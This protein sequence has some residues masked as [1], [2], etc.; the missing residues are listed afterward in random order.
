[1]G[2]T[3]SLSSTAAPP[4]GRSIAS[5][6]WTLTSGADIATLSGETTPNAAT[7]VASAAG[8]ITAQLTVTDTQG[9]QASASVTVTVVNPATTAA[10]GGGS[11][12][13][14]ALGWPWLAGLA[15]ALRALPRRQRA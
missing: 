3:I 2:G 4:S 8:S 13:G 11:S 15:L 5:Y 10:A 7:I 14:G 12:G 6:L 1:V 9:A